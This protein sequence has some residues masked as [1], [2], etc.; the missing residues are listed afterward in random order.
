MTPA[1]LKHWVTTEFGEAVEFRTCSK[2]GFDFDA[3]VAFF[4]AREKVVLN[5]G[6]LTIN[7]VNVCSHH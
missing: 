3:I 2:E 7:E 5:D 6:K 1:E 4:I